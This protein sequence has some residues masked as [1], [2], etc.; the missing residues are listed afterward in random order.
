MIEIYKLVLAAGDNQAI[1]GYVNRDE[2]LSIDVEAIL[3]FIAQ[4]AA[5]REKDGW[6]LVSVG[7]IPMRE[8]G[9]AGNVMFQSGGG[10][11]TQVAVVVVYA[12][13]VSIPIK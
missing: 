10:Y 9:T 2:S 11:A 13:E 8:T 4:D 7:G 5:E 12:R 3:K 6:R 1:V